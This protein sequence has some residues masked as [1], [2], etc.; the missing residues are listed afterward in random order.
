MI[1]NKKS[2][3]EFERRIFF[4][5][6]AVTDEEMD[7]ILAN[8]STFDAGDKAKGPGTGKPNKYVPYAFKAWMRVVQKP[9]GTVSAADVAKSAYFSY[10]CDSRER[11]VSYDSKDKEAKLK[12]AFPAASIELKQGGKITLTSKGSWDGDPKDKDRLKVA[13]DVQGTGKV[14]VYE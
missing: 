2:F 1:Y 11:V 7:A 4:F 10:V 9:G 14:R 13:W 12:A 3:V 6:E 8:A 5:N